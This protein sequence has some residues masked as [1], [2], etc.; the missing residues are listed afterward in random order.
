MTSE[1]IAELMERQIALTNKLDDVPPAYCPPA[2]DEA[3]APTA[4]ER[5]VEL[6]ERQIALTKERKELDDVPP[7][8]CPAAANEASAPTAS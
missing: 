8:Y 6:M 7:A 4:S 3:S 1:Q 2:A 5:I